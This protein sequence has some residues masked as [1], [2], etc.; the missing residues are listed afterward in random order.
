MLTKPFWVAVGERAVKTFAQALLATL[1][2]S[3]APLDV[4]H[5]NWAGALSIGLGATLLSVLTSLSGLGIDVPAAVVAQP[6]PPAVS[7]AV[8]P[9][10]GPDLP[11]A[12][13]VGQ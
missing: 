5:V 1:A 12:P 6:A 13:G 7:P 8:A 4:L 2:V 10:M 11:V 3:S 9:S